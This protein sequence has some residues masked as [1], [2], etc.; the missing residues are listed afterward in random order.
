MYEAWYE[1]I[2]NLF[3]APVLKFV[4]LNLKAIYFLDCL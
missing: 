1:D 4:S 3:E 2:I